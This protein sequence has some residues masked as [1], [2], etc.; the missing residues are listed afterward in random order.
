MRLIDKIKED[1]KKEE[2]NKKPITSSYKVY[3]V[4]TRKME[5]KER[6]IRSGKEGNSFKRITLIASFVLLECGFLIFLYVQFIIGFI[7]F[8]IIPYALGVIFACKVAVGNKNY[9]S[10]I[11]WI[12]FLL[13]FAPIGVIIYFIAGEVTNTPFKSWRMKKINKNSNL[14]LKKEIPVNLPDRVIQECSYIQNT[15]QFSI[16]FN[17]EVQYF[18]TGEAY[19]EDVLMQLKQ[20]KKFI[21]M[22]FFILEEGGLSTAIFEILIQKVKEGVDVRI[23]VDGL[24]SHGT[25]DLLKIR[26]IRKHGIKIIAFEPVI[27]IINFFMNYRN[28][29]KI[30]VIDGY[31]GYTG[32]ANIADEYINAKMKYGYWK[33]ANIKII[34]EAVKNLTLL[35]LRMWEYSSHQKVD[36]KVYLNYFQDKEY[37]GNDILIPYGDGPSERIKL[38]KGVYSNIICNAQKNLYIMTPYFIIDNYLI[39]LLKL[40]A[41]SGVDVRIIIPGIPDKKLVYELTLANVAKLI[42]SGIKVYIYKPGFLHSKVMLSDDQCAVVGSINMDFR[43]FYQQYEDAVYISNSPALNDI[44]KDFNDTFLISSLLGVKKYSIFKRIFIAII[45][46]FAPL[47]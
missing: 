43:S 1:V 16:S 36:Y 23:I 45:R 28:H 18:A 31:T 21:F 34:G 25:L 26:K 11:A 29:R 13:L 41:Q 40:K 24:G 38:G 4:K 3:N 46:L 12:L 44:L 2:D 9:D 14:L 10:K 22:D 7:W 35:F 8:L 47:M 19:F 17:N 33:D 39:D 27:P 42:D 5:T 15:S 32:G 6:I 37:I 30:I 20:A